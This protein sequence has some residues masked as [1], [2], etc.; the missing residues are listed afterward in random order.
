MKMIAFGSGG[1]DYFNIN[2]IVMQKRKRATLV[3]LG[4]ILAETLK[5]V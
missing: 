1:I 4:H 2:L 3:L 5:V